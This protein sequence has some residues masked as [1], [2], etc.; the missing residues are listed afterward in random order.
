MKRIVL[1]IP[2]FGPWPAWMRLF[3]ASCAAN[4]SVDFALVSDA[5]RP[6]PLPGNVSLK[7]MS[8]AEYRN[9]LV[10]LLRIRPRW[11]E[12]YK[13]VYFKPTLGFLFPDLVEGYDYWG[14]GDLDV[15]YGDIRRFFPD[16]RLVARI[17]STHEHIISGHFAL[18]RNDREMREA[19]K[20]ILHW[21]FF[22]EA[23]KHK[24]FDERIFSLLFL[25]DARRRER[26][27]HRFLVPRMGGAIFE[28]Q[29][30]T[31]VK[32]LRWIDGTSDFPKVWYWKDGR[33]TAEGAGD[34]EFLYLHFTHWASRRWSGTDR[35]VWADVQ[36]L[37]KVDRPET[38][39]FAVSAEG[40]TPLAS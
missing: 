14:Y 37:V 26:G 36:P 21:R 3:L 4:P 16:D 23:E 12:P 28:E 39:G 22:L 34:R 24:S 11:T 7:P 30:S 38:E 18:V 31:S 32:G 33:L 19:F 15:I 25:D 6:D 40:F 20:K 29:F 1:V 35:A 5:P 27:I 9:N 2:W 13:I 17:I 8:F 10:R